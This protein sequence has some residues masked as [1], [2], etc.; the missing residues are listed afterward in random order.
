MPVRIAGVMVLAMLAAVSSEATTARELS[1]EVLTAQAT[2][3]VSGRCT[4]IRTTWNGRVLMTMATIQVTDR[5]KGDV[6]E[7][8][9]GAPGW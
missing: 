4:S 8:I 5:L 6:A 7:T 9:A 3:I 2:A 1:N